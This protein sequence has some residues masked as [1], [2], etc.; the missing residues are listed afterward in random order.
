MKRIFAFALALS[1]AL[2]TLVAAEARNPGMYGIRPLG[3]GN[4]FV[5]IAQDFSRRYDQHPFHAVR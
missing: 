1:I 5:A 4:A 3:M 2:P